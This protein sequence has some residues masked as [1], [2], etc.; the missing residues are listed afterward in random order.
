MNVIRKLQLGRSK[1]RS[2]EFCWTTS[3]DPE[4]RG[5]PFSVFGS[6]PVGDGNQGGSKRCCGL[7]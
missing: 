3:L 7:A 6:W 1:L 2:C 5:P 4:C